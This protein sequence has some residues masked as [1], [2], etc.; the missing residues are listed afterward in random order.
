[1]KPNAFAF[2]SLLVFVPLGLFACF[3]FFPSDVK[4]QDNPQR[5]PQTQTT[6]TPNRLENKTLDVQH[7]IKLGYLLSIPKD[8][9]QKENWPV[10]LFLHGAGE[11]GENLELVKVHG[12]PKQVAAGKDLPF[13]LVAPQCP[14]NRWWEPIS[15]TA[16]LDEVESNYNVD[17]SRIYVTGLSMGGFGTWNLAAHSPERF[18]AI[19]PICGGGDPFVVARR[20]GKELPVWVFHGD[21]DNVVPIKRSQEMVEALQR[22]KSDVKFTV[23]PNVGHDSWTKTY[24]DEAF[25]EWLLS[26]RRTSDRELESADQSKARDQ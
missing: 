23:Y 15:L 9:D 12:P 19:A 3:L 13:I 16:L 26:H 17:K 20:I 1:M 6:M 7:P 4:A 22:I 10:V 8:Y 24:D 21:Q 11:R 2:R 25:Y 14:K 5:S 18:A